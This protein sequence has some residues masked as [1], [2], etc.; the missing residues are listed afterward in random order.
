MRKHKIRHIIHGLLDLLPLFVIPVFMVYSH[1]H[2]IDTY[3]VTV[4]GAYYQLEQGVINGKPN[5]LDY[6]ID[7]RE[8]FEYDPLDSYLYSTSAVNSTLINNNII[9]NTD[10]GDIMFLQFENFISYSPQNNGIEVMIQG[11]YDLYF[12]INFNISQNFSKYYAIAQFTQNETSGKLTFNFNGLYQDIG[13]KNIQLFNLTKIYGTGNEPTAEVFSSMIGDTYYE[14]GE[15]YNVFL[16]YGTTTYNATDIGSQFIYSLY[17]ATVNYFNTDSVFNLS[18]LHN[19]IT[20]N[21][22]NGNMPL[23]V[24]VVYHIIVYELIM[25]IIFLIYAVFMFIVDFASDFLEHCFTW[26]RRGGN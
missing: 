1:R 15:T 20:N 22:F 5:S 8:Y 18:S 19:W 7:S 25:D 21:F 13:F 16:P 4:N 17:N 10:N 9:S 3:S 2:T 26:S 6:W 11:D 14:Y 12:S 24:T 23:G